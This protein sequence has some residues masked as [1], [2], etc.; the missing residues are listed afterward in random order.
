MPELVRYHDGHVLAY[1]DYGHRDG[2]PT[3]VQHGMIASI[4]D[5]QLFDR[6]IQRGGRVIC[7][8]RPGYGESS[9]YRMRSMAEWGEPV[10]AL[11]AALDLPQ[12]DVL[13]L[14]SGAPYGYAIGYRFPER[15]RHI[16]VLAG[17]PA[18]YDDAIAARWPY[19]IDRGAGLPALQALAR[20]LFFSHLSED[21]L[22]KRDVIDSMSN[23]CFG[24]AQDLL[25]RCTDWGFRLADV[26]APVTM[27]HSRA[28]D[29]VPF[30]TAE[31]T[32]R[33][34]PN[35]RLVAREADPHFSAQVL[36]DFIRTVLWAGQDGMGSSTARGH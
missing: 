33:L 4:D 30:V 10:A 9:S 25:L 31:M 11:V 26:R 13:A 14:S 23:D 24:I 15:V 12:F 16:W 28:D 29:Q 34:L 32:S 7:A 27:Q 17:T 5:G 8:A 20:D 1:A 2:Y 22:S 21:E 35:C 36:D 6:L 19:P 3:L 18:L